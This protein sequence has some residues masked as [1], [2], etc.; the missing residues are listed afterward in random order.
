MYDQTQAKVGFIPVSDLE[1]K[2]LTTS[3]YCFSV[4]YNLSHYFLAQY[5][6]GI[7]ENGVSLLAINLCCAIKKPMILPSFKIF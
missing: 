3:F 1:P 5:L 4:L 6:K 2:V 7:N